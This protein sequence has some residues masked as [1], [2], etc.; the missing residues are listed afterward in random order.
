M[1]AKQVYNDE[2]LG[3]AMRHLR[4]ISRV[5]QTEVCRRLEEVLGIPMQQSTISRYEN[6][7]TVIPASVVWAFCECLKLDV[8][9]L[10]ALARGSYLRSVAELELRSR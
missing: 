4:V 1:D 7:E 5:S 10:F 3:N 9:D 2:C 6:G 8:N